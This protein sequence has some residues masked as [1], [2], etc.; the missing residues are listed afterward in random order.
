[1]QAIQ[2]ELKKLTGLFF[3]FLISFG[4]ILLVMKLLLKEYSID[5]YILTKAIVGALIAAKSV[6]IMDVT[7][8]FNRFD[9]LPCYINIL[10][11]T[12]L[13][14]AAV[15]ILGGIEHL[16]HASREAKGIGPAI[17]SFLNSEHFYHM[18]ATTL[19]IAVVFLLH[20]IFRELDTYLGKG[21]ITKFFANRP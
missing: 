11:K 10:Y 19:C 4:Y 7:P 18:L 20:N 3:F 16:F 8:L 14:T 13:Y 2:R 5:A 12:S 9:H 15:L 1:M 6:A 17:S 21:F